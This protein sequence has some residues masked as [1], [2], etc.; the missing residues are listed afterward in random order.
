MNERTGITTFKGNPV[1]LLGPELK[2]GDT[3][4]DFQLVDAD[5]Q[6]VALADFAGKTKIICAVP[7][8]DTPTCDTEARRFNEAAKNLGDSIVVLVVSLDLPFAQKH[9]CAAAGAEN[10]K[11]LSDYRD[12]SFG[13]AYGVLIKELHLLSR[14]IFVVDEKDSI[15]Y[16]QQVPEIAA[17]PDYDAALQAAKGEIATRQL[18]M[19]GICGGY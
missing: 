13:L 8:L 1:T 14:A 19:D 7:S 3:A 15:R 9:W 16:L 5:L 4:P 6:A 10:V 17:Q 12:R 2:V 11:V 18:P